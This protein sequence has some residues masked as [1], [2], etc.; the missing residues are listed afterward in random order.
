[1]TEPHKKT[2]SRLK[3]GAAFCC[4]LAALLGFVWLASA[5]LI[6]HRTEFGANWGAFQKE[7]RDSLDAVFF[8][9]S[10]VY[11]DIIPAVIYERSGI[12]SYVLAGPE[13]TLTTTEYYVKEMF[14]TQSPKLVLVEVTGVFYPKYTAYTKANIGY[15]PPSLNRLGATFRAAEPEE[16]LGLLFPP[17]NYHDEELRFE[18]LRYPAD[19]LAGYTLVTETTDIGGM[20]QRPV[21]YDEG[22]FRANIGS[23]REIARV[24]REEG[25]RVLFFLAP[26]YYPWERLPLLEHEVGAIE[27]AEFI[28]FNNHLGDLSVEVETDFFDPQHFNVWG[29]EKFSAY[30]APMLG[31]RISERKETDKTLWQRR[32]AAIENVL[33]GRQGS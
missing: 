11:C 4:F 26:N 19:D 6:P 9:S 21:E 29:A 7:K 33:S 15:M 10:I 3:E 14:R 28:N 32:V 20:L 31:E 2:T 22:V 12:S 24:C 25:S 8:G 23:L 17:Y 30:I 13:Q 27:D 5:V 1:M 16:R 18:N